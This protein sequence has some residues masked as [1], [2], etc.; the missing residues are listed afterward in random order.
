MGR[1]DATLFVHPAQL[2]AVIQKKDQI[3]CKFYRAKKCN[4]VDKPVGPNISIALGGMFFSMRH[5]LAYGHRPGGSRLS[6]SPHTV[7]SRFL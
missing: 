3:D 1:M 6:A 2:M 7:L 4:Y 5:F